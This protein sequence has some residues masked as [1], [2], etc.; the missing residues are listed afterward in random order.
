MV[1]LFVVPVKRCVNALL[2]VRGSARCETGTLQGRRNHSKPRRTHRR[3]HKFANTYVVC[4]AAFRLP[5]QVPFEFEAVWLVVIG[6]AGGLLLHRHQTSPCF[7]CLTLRRVSC[8]F[9]LFVERVS[10]LRRSRFGRHASVHGSPLLHRSSTSSAPLACQPRHDHRSS[11]RSRRSASP[12]SACADCLRRR[13]FRS[14]V[15]RRR[16]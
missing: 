16:R 14:P 12:E 13:S 4:S 6:G 9:G 1:E 5:N 11:A 7:G 10:A 15:T 2:L 8:K 3:M